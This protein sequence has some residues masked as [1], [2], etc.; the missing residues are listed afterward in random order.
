MFNVYEFPNKNI[1]INVGILVNN[2]TPV[3]IN[4]HKALK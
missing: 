4:L 1:K 3:T 2:I